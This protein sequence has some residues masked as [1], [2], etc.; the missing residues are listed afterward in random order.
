MCRVQGLSAKL[1][2]M[3]SGVPDQPIMF[4]AAVRA[5]LLAALGIRLLQWVAVH[6][7]E[8]LQWE[9]DNP[10][11]TRDLDTPED[12]DA[13]ARETGWTVRWPRSTE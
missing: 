2:P 1:I 7:N 8:T 12:I 13:L 11:Y 10:H 4:D 6:P 3:V 9:M 5:D